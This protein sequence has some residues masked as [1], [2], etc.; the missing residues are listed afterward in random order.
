MPPGRASGTNLRLSGTRLIT[1]RVGFK[2]A[3]LGCAVSSASAKVVVVRGNMT[4][5]RAKLTRVVVALATALLAWRAIGGVLEKVGHPGATLDDAFIHFQYARAIAEGH[6]LR[7]QAG[8]PISTGATSALWPLLLSPFYALGLRDVS[9]MW[10]AWGFSFA[11]LGLLAWDVGAL[12]AGLAGPIAGVV[13]SALT[14]AFGGHA[15]CAA[16]GMEVIPF[17]WLLARTLRRLAEWA[18][19]A[20]DRRRLVEI[21]LASSAASLL[22]PEGLVFSGIAALVLATW[23]DGGGVALR[24]RARGLL[25]L[26]LPG[27]TVLALRVVSGSA[28]TNTAIAKLLSENPY[29][30]GPAFYAAVRAN[31]TTFFQTILA[32]EVWSAEFIPSGGAWIAIA[33]LGAIAALAILRGRLARGALVLA[34]ALAML[35][36]CFYVTFLWNRLRYLWPFASGWLIGLACLAHGVGLVARRV[37]LPGRVVEM[38]LG[39]ALVGMFLA[40]M[41]W[42]L[43]DVAQSASGIDR[44]QVAAGRWADTH[45]PKDA[46]IGINDA[47]AI[48]YFGNRKTFDVVGLTTTGEARYWTAG[49]ASRFEHYEKMPRNRLPTHF[50]VYPDWMGSELLFGPTLA[51]F[52]VTDA[53][54]LGGQTKRAATADWSPLGTG[55]LPWSDPNGAILD[56]VDVAD[57]ESERDHGY[58]LLGAREGEEIVESGFI[59]GASFTDGGR[60]ERTRERFV[61]KLSPGRAHHVLARLRSAIDTKVRLSLEGAPDAEV[62]LAGG[63][64]REI[65]LT[66]A[67]SAARAKTTMAIASDAPLATFH[68]WMVIDP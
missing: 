32:G 23:V 11:A 16:S 46:R 60:T 68:Y 65:S 24:A 33:G 39:G 45:L 14:L 30:K 43:E 20:R 40:K 22:R 37:G 28:L 35:I 55:E 63:D 8:E 59:G 67:P 17:A 52:T 19:G 4:A 42:V 5:R 15:W 61:A 49:V 47:G 2:S 3:Q 21:V 10:A 57:L 12:T 26:A 25:P 27:L 62:A 44:Q 41:Q 9:L 48:A 34:F 6:P 36:P 56:T 53:T 51:E 58:E 29:T 66:V 1:Q 50:I 7:Y 38:V 64:W 31:L 13:A 18:E 54:I